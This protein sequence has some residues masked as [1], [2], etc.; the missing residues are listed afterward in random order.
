[1]LALAADS[2]FADG[3]KKKVRFA[4]GASSTTIRGSVIR[5]DRDRYYLSAKKRPGD[6]GKR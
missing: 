4:R 1:M 5:G 6:V 2:L 3:V